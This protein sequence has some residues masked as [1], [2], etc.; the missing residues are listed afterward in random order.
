M[1]PVRRR[2]LQYLGL[3]ALTTAA[4]TLAYNYGMAAWEGEPQPLYHSLEIVFQTFTTTGYGED[5]GWETPQM[6]LLVISMMLAGIGLILTGV[7]IFA[8]PWLR[9][10]LSVSPPTTAPDA[11]DHV[12]LCGFSPRGRA[13]VEELQ[14]KDYEY[15]V[16]EPDHDRALELSADHPV[17]HGDPQSPAVLGNAGIDEARAVVADSADDANASI[18]LSA[19]EVDPDAR[20]ITLVED[21]DL[22]RYHR[23]AGADEVLSPRRLLGESLASQIPTAVTTS[24]DDAVEI[25]EDFGLI[26]LTLTADSDLCDE[27]F[28]DA[29]IRERFSLNVIGAW[30]DGDFESPVD[31]AETLTAGT[32]LLVAGEP[33]RLAEFREETTAPVRPFAPRQ[34]IVAGFGQTGAAAYAVLEPTGTEITVLDREAGEEVDVVG[35]ARDPDVLTEAGIEGASALLL[36]LGDD[37]T[38]VFAT[39]IARDLNPD[40]EIV[41]RANDESNVRRL[42]RAGADYVQSL[43]TV[44]GRMLASTVFE[45]E[46][47]LAYDTRIQV[48]RVPADG[49]SGWT[50]VEADVRAR[51]GA[52]VLGVVTDGETI[53]DFDPG[54]LRIEADDEL[55]LAGTDESV[56]EFDRIFGA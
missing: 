23:A 56:A 10:A 9:E 4:Y 52:T 41:V 53:T 43:A 33:D 16:V 54:S 7:D 55:V 1:S 32:T 40:V 26:E 47:V 13:F 31:P 11:A 12:V 44:S 51:T 2:M 30:F 25:G 20:V 37:T 6:H 22:A 15:V 19:R 21:P 17:V 27:Q 14:S 29:R 18:V 42:Y 45:D 24:V 49:L 5:A 3:V 36:G 48:V 39:L 35:D 34:A 50:I 8:I 38:A 28:S 46:E